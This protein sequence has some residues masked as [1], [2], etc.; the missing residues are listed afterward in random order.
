M[1]INFE[2]F[3]SEEAQTEFEIGMNE[4]ANYVHREQPEPKG[5]MFSQMNI[6]YK[7]S[8]AMAIPEIGERQIHCFSSAVSHFRKIP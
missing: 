3:S 2:E 6:I 7:D 8:A 5:I 1:G 4:L